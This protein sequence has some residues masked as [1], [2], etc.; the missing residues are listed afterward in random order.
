MHHW[1]A[2]HLFQLQRASMASDNLASGIDHKSHF[3]NDA[4]YFN[5]YDDISVHEL[6]LKDTARMKAFGNF[7]ELNGP[8]FVDKIVVDVGSGTG[9]LSLFAARAGAKH[10]CSVKHCLL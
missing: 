2:L 1:S 10:V 5:S 3:N 4:D 6:M 8:Q 7:I 9:I